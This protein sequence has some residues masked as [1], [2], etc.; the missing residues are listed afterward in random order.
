MRH[1]RYSNTMLKHS[2]SAT[3]QGADSP[4]ERVF[5]TQVQRIYSGLTNAKCYRSVR[6]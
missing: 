6:Y 4:D 3:R 2:G 5:F 1:W